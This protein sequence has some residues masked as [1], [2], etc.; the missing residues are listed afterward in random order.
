[1][2][3]SWQA[4]GDGF[5]FA[6]QARSEFRDHCTGA[7]W[8][9][10]FANLVVLWCLWQLGRWAEIGPRVSQL[11]TEAQE[12][13]D[14]YQQAAFRLGLI[15]TTWLCQDDPMRAAQESAGA[16]ARWPQ[17]KF[18][19]SLVSGQRTSRSQGQRPSPGTS[20][21]WWKPLRTSL[22]FR[23][24][25]VNSKSGTCACALHIRRDPSPTAQLHAGPA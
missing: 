2:Q 14:L 19:S 12:R 6:D 15:N 22:L 8:E 24:R 17:G 16:M 7:F 11:L 23:V 3:R 20:E 13:G 9:I 5:A 1:V 21:T 10:A 4:D 18:I 25:L